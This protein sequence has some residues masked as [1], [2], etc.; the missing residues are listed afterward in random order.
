VHNLQSS[1]GNRAFLESILLIP[2][3]YDAGRGFWRLV[4]TGSKPRKLFPDPVR[5]SASEVPAH[6]QSAAKIFLPERDT[7]CLVFF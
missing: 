6:P 5:R 7:C 3:S 1:I 2:V 4:I